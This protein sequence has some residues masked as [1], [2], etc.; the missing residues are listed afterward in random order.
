[1]KELRPFLDGAATAL[2]QTDTSGILDWAERHVTFPHSDRAKRFSRKQAPWLNDILEAAT[3]NDTREI[4]LMAPVGSGKTTL[5]ETLAPWIVAREPGA[6]MFVLQSDT[7]ATDWSETRLRRVLE[8]CEP[9]APLWPKNRHLKRKAAILFPHMPLFVN[10]AN[11]NNL[12]SKSLR[13]CIGDEVWLWKPGLVGE[14]RRRTHDR[15]NSK[16]IF[17][18]QAGD[19]EDEFSAAFD[20]STRHEFQWECP[21][22][23][24]RQP[25]EWKQMKYEKHL[26]KTGEIDWHRLAKSVHMECAGCGEKFEDKPEVRRRICNSGRYIKIGDGMVGV[27][28]YTLPSM[29][30]WW[31]SWATLVEEWVKAAAEEKRGNLGPL[32]QFMQKRLAKPWQ[33]QGSG[34]KDEEVL[35]VRSDYRQGFCPVEDPWF[36]TLCADPGQN[37]THWSAAAHMQDGQIYIFDYGEV[38]A[39]ENLLELA[40]KSW[41][42]VGDKQHFA[43]AG[44]VDSGDF[45]ERIYDVCQHSGNILFPAKGTGG[46]IGVWNQTELKER[47]GLILYT[48]S[49]RTAK[50]SLYIDR[51]GMLKPPR[52]H[53]PMD[54]TEDFLRG[55]MGQRLVPSK[56]GKIKEWRKVAGDHYGDCTKLHMIAHWILAQN[57]QA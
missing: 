57:L 26:T 12:Q 10:G 2:R 53:F 9:I 1:V 44:L 20:A 27:M 56:T 48:Y 5:F 41:P 49:D 52:L 8:E 25:W 22:C 17:V 19:A 3:D 4:I 29:P 50:V 31:I 32:R 45:T 42:G 15:W 46:A 13:W 37:Q 30:V 24:A 35:R 39:P 11:I 55:H 16:R 21:H 43:Q 36:I 40:A 28:G 14:F 47:G 23:Q 54:A 33:D 38:L 34:A 18:G 6:S 7:D 51:I